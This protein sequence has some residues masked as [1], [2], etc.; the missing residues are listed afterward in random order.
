MAI[1]E[2]RG[3]FWWNDQ[4]VP[5]EQFAPNSCVHGKLTISDDGQVRLDLDTVMPGHH[6]WENLANQNR[7][8]AHNIQGLLNTKSEKVLLLG[9]IQGGGSLRTNNL[10]PESYIAANCLVSGNR[11]RPDTAGGLAF[12]AITVELS[13]LED[14]LWLKGITSHRARSRLSAKY[15][16]PKPLRFD[17][18]F[19]TLVIDYD[20]L[21]PWFGKSTSN[22]LNLAESTTI[23]I[24]STTKMTLEGCQTYS[25]RIEEL[26]LL[27]TSIVFTPPALARRTISS[28]PSC[29]VMMQPMSRSWINLAIVGITS[30][31]ATS[32]TSCPCHM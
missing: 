18:P 23:K 4:K 19:G 21:G 10:S 27:L 31:D 25:Q 8:A 3:L 26:I 16:A 28:L 17:L 14:W 30:S 1:L 7:P 13:G 20:L 29:E 5:K 22:K 2:D 24:K 32:K 11:F 12:R 15:K 6:P 9:L